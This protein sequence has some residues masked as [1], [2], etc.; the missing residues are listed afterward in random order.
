MSHDFQIHRAQ[1]RQ[2]D[3]RLQVKRPSMPES[4]KK[5]RIGLIAGSR[6]VRESVGSLSEPG[7]EITY[8]MP[9]AGLLQKHDVP[10]VILVDARDCNRAMM[11]ALSKRSSAVRLIV[12][13]ADYDGLDLV[14]CAQIG[15]NGFTLKDAGKEKIAE[16]I[17]IVYGDKKVIPLPIADR[18]YEQLG[19][20]NDRNIRIDHADLTVREHQILDLMALGMT[21]KEIAQSLNIA[22]HTA[23]THVHNILRKVGCRR[24]VE[25]LRPVRT[26]SVG[27]KNQSLMWEPEHSG[28]PD[29]APA[30]TPKI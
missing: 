20:A 7:M 13:D 2:N 11:A 12:L 18:L 27:R 21:N 9:D 29:Y 5:I 30:N 3:T 15:V 24:R 14:E 10:D 1:A 23:K 26:S 25:L 6:L 16:T 28:G 17:Q 19:M 8:S 4:G 22:S